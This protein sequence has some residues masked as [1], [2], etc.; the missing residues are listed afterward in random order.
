MIPWYLLKMYLQQH[1]KFA[2]G[3]AALISA[4]LI[5]Y[6]HLHVLLAAWCFVMGIIVSY[7]FFSHDTVLPSLLKYSRSRK[8]RNLDDELSLMK[9][10]CRVC[11][12]KKCP[13]HRPELNIL[14]FQPWTNL[15][16][17]QR[18]D[19]AVEEF[20][21]IIF[22]EFVYIWY[23]DLSQ[24][25]EFVD[26]LR[27]NM[28]FLASVLLRRMKKIDIPSLVTQK[29]CKAAI[30][31]ID[32]V[33]QASRDAVPQDSDLQQAALDYMGSHVHC[34]MWSRKAELEYLRRLTESLFPYILHRQALNSKCTCAVLREIIAGSALLPAMDAIA[35]SDML[36]NL[37]LIF[38][39]DTPPPP[40][41]EPPSPRVQFL[42]HFAIPQATNQS[43]LRMELNEVMNTGAVRHLYPFMQFLKS[44]AA[45]NVLQF[46][47]SCEDFNKQ[48][49]SPDVSQSEFVYL[50]NMAKDLYRTYVS[51][52]ALDKIKFDE[53]VVAELREVVEGPPDQVIRLRT[54]T[55][56][57]KAYEHAY[58][59]LEHTFLSLFHQSDDY[60]NMI[61]GERPNSS[62]SRQHSK[63]LK[64][65]DFGFSNIGSKIKDVFRSSSEDRS[66]VDHSD[67]PEGLSAF[68]TPMV[69]VDEEDVTT[70]GLYQERT[71]NDALHDLSSWRVTVP[72]TGAR[73]D[74]EN[75]R[76]QYYVF[77]IDVRRVDVQEG[78]KSSWTVARR[79]HEFYVL[80]Q[81]L[82]EFHGEFVD[83]QLPPKKSFGTKSQ[84]F[85]ESK[86][87]VFE[88]YLQKLLTIP[89]LKGS[90]LLY[91]F[92]TSEDEFTT[93]FLPDIKFGRFVK[94]VPMK[95][96]KEKG[97]HLDPF[98]VNF[99]Q[100]T[101]AAK[102]R[103][104]KSERRGSDA[105]Q[106]STSSEKL[107]SSLYENNVN[108]GFAPP[109]NKV[110]LSDETIETNGV[111]DSIISVAREVFGVPA[112]LHH[113]L[114]TLRMLLRNTFDRYMENYI[115]FKVAQVT[116]EHRV[117]S[118]IHLLRDVLFFDT[119]P[120][121]TDE[122]KKQRY[123]EA[124]NGVI[125]F[126]PGFVST[127]VGSKKVVVGSKFLLD[128]FQKPKLNKQLSYVI[129]D[130]FI[131]ELFPELVE[132][133]DL[134]KTR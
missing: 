9:T 99:S 54:S 73:P 134:F 14:A 66:S 92:L 100:S 68:S 21:N 124:L 32:A 97:Q 22:K 30:Y 27:T 119:D 47:L 7:S 15:E 129:L 104:Y 103:P 55:P 96:V 39:D 81:K 6:S 85:V 112:W 82:T 105:S 71:H 121:R 13:R 56:L 1:T 49:L 34:A 101:E 110:E 44:E 24:D 20:L 133:P 74:L 72:R 8:K 106:L 37:L 65:K 67:E 45:V 91:N 18:V 118:L 26:E 12:Q 40:P 130:I 131:T 25:E 90:E 58:D 63:V 109:P 10:V 83:C 98:L 77:I 59:L 107:V 69:R 52:D 87:E 64:K 43:C 84:E 93:S 132:D 86:K 5:F 108:S 88:Q 89:H 35:N 123:E 19:E 60:Y 50:H 126:I 95:L 33:I 116:Q 122:Q 79:Y 94:S 53:D 3:I 28:R 4:T 102:P 2:A 128:V 17:P 127:V 48:I 115:E 46:C 36:N 114:I 125:E 62:T 78:D 75:I 76:K 57:F 117:V 41:K 38:L 29:L 113:V 23:K 61:S 111:F 16:V 11:G 42:A 70:S 51:P 31:H 120:P 80:E